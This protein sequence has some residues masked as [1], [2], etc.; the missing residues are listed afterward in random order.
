MFKARIFP[1][2]RCGP[3]RGFS[4]QHQLLQRENRLGRRVQGLACCCPNAVPRCAKHL[5]DARLGQRVAR[6]NAKHGLQRRDVCIARTFIQYRKSVVSRKLRMQSLA[7]QMRSCAD[8]RCGQARCGQLRSA[9]P[10]PGRGQLSISDCIQHPVAL[11][12]QSA[13]DDT[14]DRPVRGAQR[15]LP[16]SVFCGKLRH[17]PTPAPGGAALQEIKGSRQDAASRNGDDRPAFQELGY[18]AV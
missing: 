4:G 14:R 18:S 8:A 13:C 9:R 15:Q 17:A 5:V 16:V 7:R 6:Q 10:W 3:G 12:V 11:V 1:T 2:F